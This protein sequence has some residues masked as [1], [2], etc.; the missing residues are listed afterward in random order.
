MATL[1]WFFHLMMTFM[2]YCHFENVETAPECK[3]P[4]TDPKEMP[5]STFELF[6]RHGLCSPT[7]E[8]NMPSTRDI[9]EGDRLRVE[10]LQA[11]FKP[12]TKTTNKYDSRFQDTKEEV[13]IPAAVAGDIYAI[14]ISLGTPGQNLVLAFDTTSD[15]TWMR[16]FHNDKL[17]RINMEFKPNDSTSFSSVSCTS[18]LCTKL[19]SNHN[20]VNFNNTDNTC[21]HDIQRVDGLYARGVLSLDELKITDDVFF[22]WIFVCATDVGTKIQIII[23]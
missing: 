10:S 12:K 9:L 14:T 2:L 22:N 1:N 5:Q 18:E 23:F 4:F 6:H 19:L 13:N 21:S 7:T 16:C 15:L 17:S 3:R 20:C 8:M 11:R